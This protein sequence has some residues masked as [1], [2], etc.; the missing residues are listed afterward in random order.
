MCRG[1]VS[2][3]RL[4]P[5]ENSIEAVVENVFDPNSDVKLGGRLGGKINSNGQQ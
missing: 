4:L 5:P 1:V 3:L 2:T